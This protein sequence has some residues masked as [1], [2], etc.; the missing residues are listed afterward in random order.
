MRR[1]RTRRSNDRNEDQDEVDRRP[2]TLPSL[3][4][5]WGKVLPPLI[6]PEGTIPHAWVLIEATQARRSWAVASA[7]GC[8]Y[9]RAVY[10]LNEATDAGRLRG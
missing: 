2:S 3:A 8:W 1:I 5:P 4:E 6:P 9:L 7:L 10:M